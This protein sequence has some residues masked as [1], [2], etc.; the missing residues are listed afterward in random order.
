MVEIFE[1][2][3]S[4]EGRKLVFVSFLCMDDG[5]DSAVGMAL[6]SYPKLSSF[7]ESQSLSFHL[8]LVV[9]TATND[10][11]SIETDGPSAQFA[12]VETTEQSSSECSKDHC[13]AFQPIIIPSPRHHHSSPKHQDSFS[14]FDS[15]FEQSLEEVAIC[16]LAL[17]SR[18]VVASCFGVLLMSFGVVIGLF[19]GLLMQ[20]S[21]CLAVNALVGAFGL[22][23]MESFEHNR[24]YNLLSFK[25]NGKQ[26]Q[27]SQP[28]PR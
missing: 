22:V 26:A 12:L 7:I 15:I 3:R 25:Y 10:V 14:T 21:V 8:V 13:S 17:D 6:G 16:P 20:L 4:N 5:L 28:S 19:G 1:L 24:Y 11:I 27:V 2:D 18:R 23:L 9:Q